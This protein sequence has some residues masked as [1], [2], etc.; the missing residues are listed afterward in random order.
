MLQVK[1]K[2][3]LDIKSLQTAYISHH[4]VDFQTIR[5]QKILSLWHKVCFRVIQVNMNLISGANT[6]VTFQIHVHLTGKACWDI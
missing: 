6:N 2:V 4:G 3:I 1:V 5:V